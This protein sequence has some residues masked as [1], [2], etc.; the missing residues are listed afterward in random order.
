MN[1][2]PL[3]RCASATKIVCPLES[4]VATAP[5][6]TGFAEI[7]SDDFP[8]LHVDRIV[9]LLVSTQQSQNDM[10][11]RNDAGDNIRHCRDCAS[12]HC[13]NTAARNFRFALFLS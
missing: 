7:V 10:K 2:F 3:S 4:T 8:E 13:G 11:G 9:P 5:T 12:L 6:P 1:L